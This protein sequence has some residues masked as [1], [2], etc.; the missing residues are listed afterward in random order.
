MNP[1][2]CVD[3]NR[4]LEMTGDLLP[5]FETTL[6]VRDSCFCM[7][8]QRAARVLARRYDAALRPLG[9]TNGQFSVLMAINRPGGASIGDLASLLAMDRTT[10]TALLKPLS[11]R[12]FVDIGTKPGD[13]RIRGL[14]LTEAGRE[15][16]REALPIWTAMQ[17]EVDGQL[18][19]PERLRAELRSLSG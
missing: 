11:R 1:Q 2:N 16:L 4:R 9:L 17:H 12:G 18:T 19:E 5:S 10:V 15:A 7:H 14:T 6:L 8:A 3:I 13:K